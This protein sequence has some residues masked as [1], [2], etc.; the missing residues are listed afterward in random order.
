MEEELEE[1]WKILE[2]TTINCCK[3]KEEKEEANKILDNLK[4]ERKYMS[5]A[6]KLKEIK[7]LQQIDILGVTANTAEDIRTKEMFKEAIETIEKNYKKK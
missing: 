2:S 3:T 7:K 1:K 4:M 6:E 5:M